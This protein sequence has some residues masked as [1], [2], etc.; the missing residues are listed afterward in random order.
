M[1]RPYIREGIA[2][3][4]VGSFLAF[5]QNLPGMQA[6]AAGTGKATASA[7]KTGAKEKSKS[8]AIRATSESLGGAER[9]LT[10]VS[11]D[12]PIYKAG[13]KV[14]ARGVM[15]D[16]AGHKPI[17]SAMTATIEIKGPKGDTITSGMCNTD[18]GVWGFAWE[19]PDG[20]A[21]GE[22]TLHASYPMTG[23]APATRKFDIRA[24]RA[25]RL[26]SQIT[27]LRDGYGPGE[28][29]NATLDVKR[30]E[31]GVPEGARV[32]VTARVD[33]MSVDGGVSTVDSKGLCQ[34]SFDLPADIPRGEGTLALVIEDGGVV[35]TAT[36]TIPI[37]LQTVD[38]QLY[39]EGGDLVAGY[40]NRVY[41][42]ANQPNGKP[43]DLAGSVMVKRGPSAAKVADFR[44]EHEGRG[45]FEFVPEQ[46][47]EYF[48]SIAEPAGIKTT[49]PL[50]A[51]KS[52]GAIIRA[53]REVYGKKEPVTVQI[54][55]SEK[56]VRVGISKH[57]VQI[58]E[59]EID[60]DG[61]ANLK[62]VS[63]DIPADAD[64]V[65]TVTAYD[66]AGTPLA[67]RLIFRE[68][69]KR[70]NLSIKAEK[71]S[72]VP[73]DN[74]KVTVKA[75]DENGNPVATIVGLTVTDD[76]VLEMIE[77]REQAPHLP[78][79]VYLEPEVKDLADAH[80]YL[81]KSNPK[82]PLATDLLLG[83][84]GWRRFALMDVAEFLE[85]EGED[86]KRVVAFKSPPDYSR[87]ALGGAGG[88]RMFA[89]GAV[90]AP[91]AMPV[92]GVLLQKA[93]MPV[94]ALPPPPAPGA[95]AQEEEKAAEPQDDRI[96]FAEK[97]D[98]IRFQAGADKEI[99]A[100]FESRARRM[101]GRANKR[102]A[103]GIRAD[104]LMPMPA[105]MNLVTVR[106]FSHEIRKN[107]QPNDRVDFAETL[108]WNA[109]LKTDPKTGEATIAFGLN[110][111]VTTFRVFAD[112]FT[113]D[114]AIGAAD[115][116]V[117]SVQPFYTEAKLPLEVTEGDQV[118]VPVS[119]VNATES[120]LTAA[121]LNIDLKGD[122]KLAD[123]QKSGADI[124]AGGRV[125]WIQPVDVGSGNGE[126]DFVLTA[127]AG[128]F[129]D[130]VTRKLSVKPK[131][132]PIES[133]FGGML[134]PGKSVVHTINVPD[135]L[136][137]GSVTSNTAVYPT[138]LANLTEAL[139]RMIQD[140]YGCFEQTS[141]TSYP[142]TMAQQY[143][144]SHTGVDPQIVQTSREKLDAGYQRLVGFWCPDRGY[145]WFGENP[146]HEALTA[147]GLLHFND[148]GKVREV[149]QKMITTTRSWLMK[150]KDGKG[151]FTRK[152]RSLH[153]WIEDK[154]CSN[155]YILWSLLETGQP[156]PDLKPEIDSLKT[157]AGS[158]KNSYVV[159]LAANALELAGEK[160]DARKLMDRLSA[161]Q[162]ADGSV[163]GVTGSIVGSGGESLEV[164]GTALATLAWLRE[165]AY[166]ANVEKSIK[167]LADSCKNGRYGSTQAT[168]L[169]L[170][171]I[172]DYDKQRARPKAPGK[173]RLFVDGQSIGDWV[174]FGK[175]SQG[176]IKLPD[177]SE[178]IT[179]GEH[180]LELRMEEGSAMPYSMAVVYNT[181]KPASADKC[182]LA[183]SVKLA[184]DKVTEG[185]TTEA[186]VT[187]ENKTK[188]VVPTPVA[189][190]GL[191]GGLEPRHDQL[192]ELVKKHT[193]DAYEVLGREVVL[194]WRTLP[195]EAK[196][197]VPLSLVAAIPGN[198]TGPASRA[199]LY[200]TD[201]DKNWVDGV[202]VEIAAK[203]GNGL[204][205][206]L[207]WLGGARLEGARLGGAKLGGLDLG[208]LDLG[209][210]ELGKLGAL[211]LSTLGRALSLWS[212]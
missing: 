106:E 159:A 158:S 176:S 118:L 152:R 8:K 65:L 44:T 93:A 168:V 57:E 3:A 179:P 190:V 103:A 18:S 145:E 186:N 27:F 197:T 194:Y 95:P 160:D 60:L 81:D 173:V 135:N 128:A 201:E 63:F 96:A 29:V 181:L 112:G 212:K 175:D 70:V 79:M 107:R 33:G 149:D 10:M 137:V 147:F 139:Q 206:N 78:V 193:I 157:A 105:P 80:V 90:M 161:K 104:E 62:S 101:A 199:Y 43:A 119:L 184:Q 146:G 85:R 196:L 28:K 15:L 165:P 91:A 166:V 182:K 40:N 42:Q 89:E 9:Y 129:K 115:A 185:N 171:A 41:V 4:L 172:V 143:F 123:L 34:V 191:P 75:T 110:D 132:F 67:E 117:E 61:G 72:Y 140:P 94:N 164:E 5:G 66:S 16:A 87:M 84:Q 2:V 210:L 113:D 92:R 141:S 76:S 183:L 100:P 178:L 71:K 86:A 21:G 136:V 120:S 69:A 97:N 208:K 180:K 138:P 54:G 207:S 144:Q 25:P 200:Y 122:F 58:A 1:S 127:S 189:I 102:I 11:T 154:D 151:G 17:K 51:V 156:A 170:R 26:K 111:S 36:K 155:A 99:A 23:Y 6:G 74:A 211:D 73:G 82:A 52:R 202:K 45:R 209:K 192:K 195:A 98:A 12:K 39:P 121:N 124:G 108:F 35:E 198:Y 174:A 142:L 30:S 126:K 133:S 48:L 109:G 77:K 205:P 153:T 88:V 22:Y 163:D 130:K 116:G 64:G 68:P 187:V 50:P 13:E 49:Y 162:K 55:G 53:D 204:G 177:M 38:L 32:T 14:Y 131:G 203:Q 31:G 47:E 148:M 7:G 59:K 24:Y 19:V 56:A 188:E 83:T 125:R 20:Q 37:L 46:G 167:Y 150:Q 114:G 169:A 134:E